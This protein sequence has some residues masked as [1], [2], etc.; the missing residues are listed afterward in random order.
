MFGSFF[1][2]CRLGSMA[3]TYKSYSCDKNIKTRGTIII[4]PMQFSGCTAIFF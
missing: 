3:P 1:L 4:P 2:F